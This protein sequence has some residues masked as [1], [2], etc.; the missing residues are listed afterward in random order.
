MSIELIIDTRETEI[1]K[2]LQQKTS[3][4]AVEQL[5]IGDILFRQDGET[6]MVIERKTV[7]DL[8]ASICDNRAREQKARL[9]GTTPRARIMYLIEGSMDMSLD[10]KISG[11]PVSTLVGS[12]INTQLRDGIKTYKTGSINESVEFICKL[13]DK[14]LKDGDNYFKEEMTSM[15]NAE[16]SSTLKKQKKANM[17]PQVWLIS[18]LSL[19]PQVSEKIAESITDKYPSVFRLIGDFESTPEHMRRKLLSDITF[20]ITGGKNRRIGDKM[21]ARIHDFLYGID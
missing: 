17:T 19:I 10:S 9:I 21:S 14:L 12:L 16:Y 18:Q 4:I 3:K 8:K 20:P 13:H 1:I 11:L 2:R 7:K 6:I 15:S 5:D